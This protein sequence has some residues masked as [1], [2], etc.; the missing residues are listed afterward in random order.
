[1]KC[2]GDIIQLQYLKKL[3]RNTKTCKIVLG[4]RFLKMNLFLSCWLISAELANSAL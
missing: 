1:M 2:R 3:K 4:V